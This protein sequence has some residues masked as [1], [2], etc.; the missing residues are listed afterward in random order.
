MTRLLLHDF[1]PPLSAQFVGREGHLSDPWARWFGQLQETL[2]SYPTKRRV[3]S[4]S[5]QTKEITATDLG[6][7]G[8]AAGLYRVEYY[9][10]ITTAA[11]VSSSLTVT[12]AWTDGGVAQSWSGAAMTGNTTATNQSG[13]LLIR[14]D[15]ATAVN[16]S[17]TY[18]SAG[19][20]GADMQYSLDMALVQ[21][22]A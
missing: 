8:L 19:G 16:Y 4:L 5:A 7:G 17:A 3:V 6:P 22:S 13:A 20:G 2:K 1:S 15:K 18:A 21:V 14:I 10:R 9:A 11:G 12:F